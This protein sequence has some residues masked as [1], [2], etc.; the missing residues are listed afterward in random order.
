MLASMNPCTEIRGDEKVRLRPDD[1][2]GQ[3]GE[4]GKDENG[5]DGEGEDGEGESEGLGHSP[6]RLLL[7]AWLVP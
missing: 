7:N 5:E 6:V 4:D 3:H 1:Q 2:H